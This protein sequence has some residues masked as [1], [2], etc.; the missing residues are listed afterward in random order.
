MFRSLLRIPG[1][2]SLLPRPLAAAR[3]AAF[4]AATRAR[5]MHSTSEVSAMHR[6]PKLDY[7]IENGISE[8]LSPGALDIAWTRYMSMTLEHLSNVVYDTEFADKEVKNIVTMTA[9]DPET[10][11]IFN[12]ASAAHNNH[13]FF[14]MLDNNPAEMPIKLQTDLQMSFGTIDNLRR[15]MIGTALA[16]FGPGFVW[17]VKTAMNEYRVM[18]TYLAGSPY[19]TAHWRAQTMDMNTLGANNSASSFIEST[20][21]RAPSAKSSVPPGGVAVTPLLCLNT[22][23]HVW[24]TDYGIEG[25]KQYCMN[26][27][28]KINWSK[29]EHLAGTVR[30]ASEPTD[31]DKLRKSAT[32]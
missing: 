17:L 2:V 26:W 5:A 11:H 7:A 27:W 19:P 18:N 10:A 15:E 3:P 9:R 30:V 13:I 20:Q 29:V 31:P 1:A 22:W 21:T 6:V 32:A 23:E 24:L 4:I 16:M 12:Y 28:H 14:Q 8:F 25:K